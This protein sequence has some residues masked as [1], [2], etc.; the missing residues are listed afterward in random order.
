MWNGIVLE[1]QE[2]LR[3]MKTA[4]LGESFSPFHP[5]KDCERE[6]YA[7]L[8]YAFTQA[9]G[10]L[11]LPFLLSSFSSSFVF[12]SQTIFFLCCDT[13]YCKTSLNCWFLLKRGET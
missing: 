1:V 7:C 9:V 12:M 4:E 10:L 3:G 11:L 5:A 6:R 13:T 2:E 8:P